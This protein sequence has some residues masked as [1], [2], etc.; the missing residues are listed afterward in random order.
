MLLPPLAAWAQTTIRGE[1]R[2]GEGPQ[3]GT[4]LAGALISS[5]QTNHV[6][7]TDSTGRFELRGREPITTLTVNHLGHQAQTYGWVRPI[8][9]CALR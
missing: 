4:P 8:R 7:T 6:A 9:F 1:V 3:V 2:E 5:P